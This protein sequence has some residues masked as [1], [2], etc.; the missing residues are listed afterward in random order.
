MKKNVLLMLPLMLATII[1]TAQITV[2]N[3]AFPTAGQMFETN[4]VNG[5]Q[6][7]DVTPAGANQ[8]WD[9]ANLQGTPV[10]FTVT[11]AATGSAAALF[12]TANVI[13]PE[14]GG[15]AGDGYVKLDANQMSTVGIVATLDGFVSDFPVPLSSPRIDL[16]T[17]MTFGNTGTGNFGFQVA[18]DP[19]VPAGT[20][21]DSIITALE[22]GA[23]G[24]IAIDSIRVT[25]TTNRSTEVDAWGSLKT[26]TG[27]FDVLRLKKIDETN[28]ILE[29]KISVFGIP[30]VLWQDPSDPNGLGIDPSTLPF[31]GLDT[32]ITYEFWDDKEQQPILKFLTDGN[33]TATYGQY[34]R[35][36]TNTSGIAQNY[37][38]RAFPNPATDNFTLEMNGLPNG[39]YRLKVYNIIG[40]EVK[41]QLFNVEGDTQI[42]VATN[43]FDAGTYVYRI[44]NNDNQSILT[45]RIVVVRP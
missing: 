4:I 31:V 37:E 20:D 29:I 34:A 28:T 38:V 8:T 39:E 18:L 9:M 25:F 40:K 43:N 26:P 13:I 14:I 22:A 10:D 32:I 7:L 6:R 16:Q 30:N 19:H 36:A 5:L 27:T 11:A 41:S 12:P 23:G 42:N 21:I 33:G 1:A 2:T 3:A 15:I 17:P 45:R 35:T 44:I 24:L